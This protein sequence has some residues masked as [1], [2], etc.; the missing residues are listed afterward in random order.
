MYLNVNIYSYTCSDTYIFVYICRFPYICIFS[1]ICIHIEMIIIWH[2]QKYASTRILRLVKTH[3]CVYIYVY[4]CNHIHKRMYEYMCINFLVCILIY[5]YF[6]N[7]YSPALSLSQTPFLAHALTST[8]HLSSHLFL[9]L[10]DIPLIILHTSLSPQTIPLSQLAFN[11]SFLFTVSRMIVQCSIIPRSGG[12]SRTF[13]SS[14]GSKQS[15][16]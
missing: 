11:P 8:L 10:S 3:L 4:L 5:T 9:C 14:R 2:I 13:P 7:Q 6:L 12:N 16:M 15:Q 1:Q